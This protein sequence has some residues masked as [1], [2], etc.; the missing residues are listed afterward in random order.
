MR[1]DRDEIGISCVLMRHGSDR[2]SSWFGEAA[3]HI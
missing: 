1:I 2:D 3:S